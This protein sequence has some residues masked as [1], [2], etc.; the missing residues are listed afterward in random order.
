MKYTIVIEKDKEGKVS[1][2]RINEG[3]NPFELVGWV[4]FI[5]DDLL[6]QIAEGMKPDIVRK[7]YLDDN[8]KK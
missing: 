6:S 4:E 8:N 2:N 3:F 1:M 5:K 7:K